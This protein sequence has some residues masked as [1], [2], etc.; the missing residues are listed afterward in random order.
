M[1]VKI[2]IIDPDE[3]T[4]I[5][6]ILMRNGYQVEAKRRQYSPANQMA[7]KMEEQFEI[8]VKFEINEGKDE[9]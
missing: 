3:A 7:E 1:K 8:Y 5:V 2:T 9:A 6:G 4:Q